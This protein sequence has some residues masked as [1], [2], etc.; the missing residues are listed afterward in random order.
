MFDYIQFNGLEIFISN[1]KEIMEEEL[2]LK[3]VLKKVRM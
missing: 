1:A 3:K 2:S